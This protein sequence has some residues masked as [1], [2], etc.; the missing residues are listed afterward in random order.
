MK[1]RRF[2]IRGRM[3]A[4]FGLI[5]LVTV[6][7]SAAAWFAYENLSRSFSRVVGIDIPSI[8]LAS[9]LTAKSG[10][11]V[12]TAP[13]LVAA[14]SNR[15]RKRI[16]EQ[17][18]KTIKIT[19]ALVNRLEQYRIPGQ[20]RQALRSQLDAVTSALRGLDTNVQRKFWFSTRNHELTE[21]LRWAHADFLD[22]IDPLVVDARFNIALLLRR[23]LST[24][25]EGAAGGSIFNIESRLKQQEVLLQIKSDV[26][27]LVGLIFRAANADDKQQLKSIS[28]FAADSASRVKDGLAKLA[29][30][31]GNVSLRQSAKTILSFIDGQNS[32]IDLRA[33]SQTLQAA[34]AD[35]LKSTALL[36]SEFQASAGHLAELVKAEAI[37]EAKSASIITARAKTTLI[38]ATLGSIVI[39]ILVVWF[40]VG[41]S[42]A[43]RVRRLNLAMGQIAEG[44]LAT[45]VPIGGDDEISDMANA[46]EV[47]R[48]RISDTQKELVQAGKLA[49]LGQLV[50]GVAHDL[51]Q[52]LAALKFQTHNAQ[53]Q[54]KK[55]EVSQAARNLDKISELS[56]K[57]AKKINHLKTLARKPS[58]S[59]HDVELK[60]VIASALDLLQGRIQDHGIEVI[61]K[62]P[63]KELFVRG[64]ENRLEQVFLNVFGNALD[65]M[66]VSSVKQM[67]IGVQ[68]SGSKTTISVKDSGPG[69]AEE[70]LQQI[71]DPFF[72]TKDVGEGLGLGLSISYNIVKDF[73]GTISVASKIDA[74]TTFSVVLKSAKTTQSEQVSHGK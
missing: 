55:D 64:G 44:D 72:T 23:S 3:F 60:P 38:W 47:F 19:D 18:L 4:A 32:L 50:A 20:Q 39:A 51:N 24:D 30:D 21:S 25:N 41:R 35:M 28:L 67:V 31:T 10:E 53:V 54:L 42:L 59:I 57:M 16:W 8:T 74:G 65:A 37:T 45:E 5:A 26:N 2:G 1:T 15:A 40:Y 13:T 12:S 69:I 66:T 48:N 63:D 22:E 46:L 52:P 11:I 43:G 70:T 62:L 27:L 58:Q 61:Q 68:N 49:A 73:G 36:V 7:S 14:S 9:E 6:I 29:K 33:G 71:F 17:L 34:S 56:T